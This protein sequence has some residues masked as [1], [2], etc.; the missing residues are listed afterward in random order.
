[1]TNL[2]VWTKKALRRVLVDGRGFTLVEMLIV[3][4]I[5]GVLAAVA[6]PSFSKVT[7][8]AKDKACDANVKTLDNLVALHGLDAGKYPEN[9]AELVT[10]GYLDAKVTCPLKGDEYKID[11]N[12]GDVT[13]PAGH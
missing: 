4:A 12:T 1:M 13:C 3:L 10:D 5:M 9:V 8:S 6:V 7:E 11:G 2:L